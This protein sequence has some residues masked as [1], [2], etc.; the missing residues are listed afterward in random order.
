M[1]TIAVLW[2]L[3]PDNGWLALSCMCCPL[4]VWVAEGCAHLLQQLG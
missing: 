2:H 1:L 3:N 4:A